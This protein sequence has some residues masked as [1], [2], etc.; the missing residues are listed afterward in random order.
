M[1]YKIVK[2]IILLGF[3]SCTFN[4]V[5]GQYCPDAR[6]IT[7]FSCGGTDM[8]SAECP[9]GSTC[10][11]DPRTRE[12]F[13]C[14]ADSSP[15]SSPCEDPLVERGVFT[16]CTIGQDRTCPGN[17]H[18]CERLGG[19]TGMDLGL[20]CPQT[21]RAGCER[22]SPAVLEFERARQQILQRRVGTSGSSTGSGDF[23]ASSSSGGGD[24]GR[25]PTVDRFG[26]GSPDPQSTSARGFDARQGPATRDQGPE[27][28]R[29]GAGFR[30]RAPADTR[31]RDTPSPG[32]PCGGFTRPT[33][34]CVMVPFP[35]CPMGQRCVGIG[36]RRGV[37]CPMMPFSPPFSPMGGFGMGPGPRPMGRGF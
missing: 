11:Q 34:Y 17:C 5:R 26:G 16:T 1:E 36:F 8:T 32:S 2:V 10:N 21:Q 29:S 31:F 35:R 25:S 20:C 12:S 13:C 6:R 18:T 4:E 3:F 7:G 14:W 33:S 24:F 22:S 15:T 9:R 37:C 28:A 23:G 19:A 27:P 30:E